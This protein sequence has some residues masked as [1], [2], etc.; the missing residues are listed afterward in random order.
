MILAH[1]VVFGSVLAASLAGAPYQRRGNCVTVVLP[2]GWARVEW[3]SQGAFYFNRGWGRAEIS[4]ATGN[5]EAVEFTD[6]DGINAVELRCAILPCGWRK[7]P[8][9]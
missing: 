4:G 5:G 6:R 3:L 8:A 1:V 2:G 7:S 9:G